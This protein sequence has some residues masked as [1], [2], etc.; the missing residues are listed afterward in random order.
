MSSSRDTLGE[1]WA[2]QQLSGQD[3]DYDLWAK[4]REALREM[5]EISHS[6]LFTVDVYKERYDFASDG[7]ADIFGYNR[8]HIRTIEKQGDLLEDRIH[9]DDRDRM[10]DLQIRH[11]RFIYSLPE[12][13]RNDFRNIYQFRMLNARGQYINVVSRNLVAQQDRNGK[14]WIVMG[15][16]D[17]AP[18]QTP[19]DTVKYSVLDMK[20]GELV[21]IFNNDNQSLTKREIEILQL[22]RQGLLS[23]EIADRLNISIYTV[24]NHRKNIL[25]KL[26]A[27]NAIEAI[28]LVNKEG[29][30][31]AK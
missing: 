17:I 23:K 8:S 10:L 7:F 13:R 4:R 29:V 14:A 20:S 1:L 11:S 19:Q 6:C 27:N 3:V 12:E 9:P 22:I 21:S 2:R 16:M 26:N 15:V 24:N 28:N 18:D 5:A 25:T 30:I 31:K